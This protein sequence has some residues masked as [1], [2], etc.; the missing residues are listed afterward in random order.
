MNLIK[1]YKNS[2]HNQNIDG[3][4]CYGSGIRHVLKN[5]I[6]QR[7]WDSIFSFLNNFSLPRPQPSPPD[8]KKEYYKCID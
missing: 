2:Y 1:R 8:T 6:T 5:T 3:S 4:H 7:G